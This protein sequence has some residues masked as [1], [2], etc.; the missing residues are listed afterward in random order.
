MGSIRKIY[1]VFF[2]FILIILFSLYSNI[3]AEVTGPGWFVVTA[4]PVSHEE[5]QNYFKSRKSLSIQRAGISISVASASTAS[6]DC[7]FWTAVDLPEP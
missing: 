3:H 6:G 7:C 2:V 1:S 5:A 4:E